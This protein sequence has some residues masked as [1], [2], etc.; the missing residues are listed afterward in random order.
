MLQSAL[1]AAAT[2]ARDALTAL[3]AFDVGLTPEG[4]HLTR[5]N[6]H[7]GKHAPGAFASALTSPLTATTEQ[8]AIVEELFQ[9][10]EINE[11]KQT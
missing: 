4:G 5:E 3:L 6:V 2:L 7:H 10:V 8:R 11:M 9:L 1:A